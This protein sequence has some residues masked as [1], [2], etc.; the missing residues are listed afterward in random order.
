MKRKLMYLVV[1]IILVTTLLSCDGWHGFDTGPFLEITAKGTY[2]DET[3]S[4]KGGVRATQQ[5]GMTTTVNLTSSSFW[6]NSDQLEQGK[7][8]AHVNGFIAKGIFDNLSEFNVRIVDKKGE[9]LPVLTKLVQTISA[10]KVDHGI[11][12]FDIEKDSDNIFQD[13]IN[14]NIKVNV[15]VF[16]YAQARRLE[17][18]ARED[19][20]NYNDAYNQS[21]D[22]VLKALGMEEISKQIAGEGKRFTNFHELDIRDEGDDN[23]LLVVAG[24]MLSQSEKT[25]DKTLLD[26]LTDEIKTNGEIKDEGL[27]TELKTRKEYV[28]DHLD[29][30]VANL[31]K[32]LEDAKETVPTPGDTITEWLK[33]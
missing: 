31:N 26:K 27:K 29:E 5:Q 17:K 20:M 22:E 13:I 10:S 16:S 15:N 6:K 11:F 18:L 7:G 1:M 14:K 30:I 3:G 23:G 4:N 25:S 19:N 28:R 21:Q 32:D 9:E 24:A 8:V 33:K 2:K 12:E